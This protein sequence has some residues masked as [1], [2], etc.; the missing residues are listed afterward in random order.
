MAYDCVTALCTIWMYDSLTE[1]DKKVTHNAIGQHFL[2][3]AKNY[4]NQMMK[5][6]I[7]ILGC[8]IVGLIF[9]FRYFPGALDDTATQGL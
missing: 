1:L 5:I 4:F 9:F 6:F 7:T 8:S 2:F 3:Q